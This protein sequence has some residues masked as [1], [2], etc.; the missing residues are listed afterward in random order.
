MVVTQGSDIECICELM[1]WE[2]KCCGTIN[3][4]C[5]RDELFKYGE[6]AGYGCK[7]CEGLV[8]N[9]SLDDL[10]KEISID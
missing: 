7:Y 3:D 8:D 10:T 4:K 6:I 5:S 2:C 1:Y 9:E